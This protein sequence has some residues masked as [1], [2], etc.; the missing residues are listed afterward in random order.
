MREGK[1]WRVHERKEGGGPNSRRKLFL[2]KKKGK[3]N[4]IR[5]LS[6]G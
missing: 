2:G 5:E 3:G 1:G 4:R 6:G